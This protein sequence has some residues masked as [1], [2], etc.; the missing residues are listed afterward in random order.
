MK[1]GDD[2]QGTLMH[3][4]RGRLVLDQLE[5]IILVHHLAGSNR[6]ILSHPESTRIGHGRH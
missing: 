6:H 3:R 2:E 5:E 4:F 1:G